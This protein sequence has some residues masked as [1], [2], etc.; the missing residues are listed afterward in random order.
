M[1]QEIERKYLVNH[2]KWAAA[3]KPEGAFLRQ[4]YI[5]NTPTKTIRVRVAD[6]QSHL[7]IKGPNV[8]ATRP[9]FEYPIPTD[10]AKELLDKFADSDL[11]K[12][13]YTLTFANRVWEVDEF[14]GENEGLIVAEIELAR[15]DETFELPDWISLEVTNDERYYNSNLS[16]KPFK[17]W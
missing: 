7:T 8:G 12:I 17:R 15:E 6:A 4:G 9:E 16:T 11:S 1:P 13:R 10:E 2:E 14:L 3:Q 5:V